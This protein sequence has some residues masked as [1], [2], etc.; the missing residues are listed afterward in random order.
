MNNLAH[1]PE[2]DYDV[3][4]LYPDIVSYILQIAEEA[5]RDPGDGLTKITGENIRPAALVEQ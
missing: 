2:E 1:D 5:K 4:E 3:Q